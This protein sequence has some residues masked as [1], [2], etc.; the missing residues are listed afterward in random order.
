MSGDGAFEVWASDSGNR[1]FASPDL[2]EA[3]DWVARYRAREGDEA[4]AAL[5]VGGEGDRLVLSG[6]RLRCL[7]D[8]RR[9]GES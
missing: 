7:L 5:S 4:L 6:E 1:V 2:N 3:L 8:S 9:D